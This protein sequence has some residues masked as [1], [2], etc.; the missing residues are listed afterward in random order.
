[1]FAWYNLVSKF[2]NQVRD[3]W[4]ATDKKEPANK[5]NKDEE[6]LDLF[7]EESEADKQAA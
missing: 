2:N 1:M 7:G 6:D 4:K 3:S 5:L